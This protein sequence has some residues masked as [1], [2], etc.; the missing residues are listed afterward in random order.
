MDNQSQP[1]KINAIPTFYIVLIIVNHFIIYYLKQNKYMLISNNVNLKIYNFKY[2]R[3]LKNHNEFFLSI[4]SISKKVN[5]L[6]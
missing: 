6:D 1:L 5:V 4:F 2:N 3:I